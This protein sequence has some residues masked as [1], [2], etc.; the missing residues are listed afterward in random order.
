MVPSIF[1]FPLSSFGGSAQR[2]Q[3]ALK[4]AVTSKKPLIHAV[5]HPRM[6][7]LR[8]SSECCFLFLFFSSFFVPAI[9]RKRI[10][11]RHLLV[12]G[13]PNCPAFR[14]ESC[15][16]PS[17]PGL[18]MEANHSGIQCP[19]F[20]PPH[21]LHPRLTGPM[22]FLARL[23]N[24]FLFL[25]VSSPLLLP[26]SPTAVVSLYVEH[27]CGGFGPFFPPFP[28]NVSRSQPPEVV[29]NP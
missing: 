25:F 7:P 29:A 4:N 1:S 3:P 16:S 22:G 24:F 5:L 27:Y 17:L 28:S 18:V 14:T 19:R 15:F 26:F 6:E 2:D 21:M 11:L 8:L 20:S 13:K 10:F 12:L 9:C 23:V